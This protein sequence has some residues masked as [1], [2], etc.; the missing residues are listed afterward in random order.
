MVHSKVIIK[1]PVGLH[2][3]PAANLVKEAVR[4]QCAI[5]VEYNGKTADAKSIL[6]VLALG[7]GCG[8]EV[9]VF[10]D[11]P[12]EAGALATIVALIES[13]EG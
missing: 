2:A 13:E 4:H 8:E 12:G 1:N 7:A 10:A 11:G 5:R 9:E 3:R 6:Q